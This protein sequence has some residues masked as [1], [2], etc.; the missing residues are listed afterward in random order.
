M[1]DLHK[2]LP[3]IQID[4]FSLLAQL[5]LAARRDLLAHSCPKPQIPTERNRLS[6][7]ES[8][9]SDPFWHSQHIALHI[10]MLFSDIL[11]RCQCELVSYILEIQKLFKLPKVFEAVQNKPSDMIS[12]FTAP[13][14]ERWLHH[15][16][17]FSKP[18]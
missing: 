13:T 3:I 11:Q 17:L 8:S 14:A 4:A 10:Q 9:L 1:H 15:K 5:H 16:A 6:H 18:L 12:Y 2:R 7:T